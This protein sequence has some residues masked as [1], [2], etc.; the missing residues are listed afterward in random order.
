M[1][2]YI[3]SGSENE[4][5]ATGLFVQLFEP[6][7]VEL[8]GKMGLDFAILDMEHTA[9]TLETVER[10]SIAAES[11]DLTTIVRLPGHDGNTVRRV[12]DIGA[13]GILIPRISSA[14]D[15]AQLRDAAF[16]APE[17]TRGSCSL[18]RAADFTLGVDET[19]HKRENEKTIVMGL[20]EL[21]SAVHDIDAILDAE[22]LD[23]IVL[24]PGDLS[25]S[26]GHAGNLQHP[27]VVEK[28]ETVLSAANDV[29]VPVAA[30][31]VSDQDAREW[32]DRGANCILYSDVR[33]L[34][35]ALEQI[36]P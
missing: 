34:R 12:L 16:F 36:T 5:P 33:L 11:V 20:I 17:G 6:A 26:M 35:S 3:S 9:A 24:G 28:L 10:I 19:Y 2:H 27:A 22:L 32:V 21:E 15:V 23:A 30:Y 4:A 25:Q 1:A 18:T 14:K 29:N 7:V 13:D 31:A 8:A